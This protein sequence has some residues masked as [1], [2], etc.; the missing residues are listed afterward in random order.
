MPSASVRV[1][2]FALT[3]EEAAR[4]FRASPAHQATDLTEQLVRERAATYPYSDDALHLQSQSAPPETLAIQAMDCLQEQPEP[5][6]LDRW[7]GAA[8]P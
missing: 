7:V 5:I 2:E 8:L 3:P 1:I 6:D 4:R